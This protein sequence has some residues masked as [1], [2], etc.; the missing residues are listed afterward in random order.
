MITSARKRVLIL[1]GG[2]G[3]VYTAM[4][5]EKLRGRENDF[6]ITLISRDNYFVYQPM[7]PEVISGSIGIFDTVSPLRRLLP[8]TEIQVREVEAVDL[9]NRVVTTSP[10]FRPALHTLPYDHLV[11]ALGDV[12]DFR[13][14]IGLAEHAFPF[15]YLG[16]ALNLRNHAIHALE[17]A[18][19]EEDPDLKAGL[20]TFVVAGGGFSGVE[21][22][23]E[24][25][26]FVRGVARSYRNIRPDA[27]RMVLLHSQDRIL[28][29]LGEKLAQEAH[30]VL[31]QRGVEIRL[32]TRLTAATGDEAILEDGSK[33]RTETLVS[34]VPKS[35]NPIIDGMELPKDRGRV[36]VDL[37][38]QVEGSDHL[39][40]V[41]DCALIPNPSGKGFCPPTAQH[42]VR[43]GQLVA[44]NIAAALRGGEQKE[45]TF[46]GLGSMASLGHHSAV[47]E[48]F[49]RQVHGLLAWLMWRT[50]YL[51]KLPGWDRQVRTGL[52]WFM[53]LILPPDIVQLKIDRG[54]GVIQ[55]HYEPGEAVFK[56]DDLG[57]RLYIIVR[58][59]CEVVRQENGTENKLAEFGPGEYFGEMALLNRTT[60]TATVRALERLDVVSIPKRELSLLVTNLPSLR[61][62]FHEVM[63]QRL[64]KP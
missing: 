15:K 64:D 16:D 26:D 55:E 5:L 30:K 1:G 47:A 31:T 9:Q 19:I 62:S 38:M 56:Q 2:F 21:C 52:S 50:I 41:G 23:A 45:F 33:I 40:A 27:I 36:K 57:D 58:G 6:E 32:N 37:R 8:R 63:E 22:I 43:E 54:Q 61:E 59:R 34:T 46:E 39:W 48:V 53:D 49:G 11:L 4:A 60:R 7:L 29:E 44:H 13:N 12:T 3:G 35:P 28:P 14:C 17:E 18:S 51:M 10:G 25:N 20:L 24:L 42:A